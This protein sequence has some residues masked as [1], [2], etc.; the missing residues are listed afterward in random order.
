MQFYFR[1]IYVSFAH[2]PYEALIFLHHPHIPCK[3]ATLI[4]GQLIICELGRQAVGWDMVSDV[5]RI[6]RLVVVCHRLFISFCLCII[7][8]S[9]IVFNYVREF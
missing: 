1:N 8:T 3:S 9:V 6:S 4:H 7:V 5:L 2:L